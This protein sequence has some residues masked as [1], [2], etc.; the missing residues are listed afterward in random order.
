M[1]TIGSQHFA[2]AA[3]QGPD[4]TDPSSDDSCSLGVQEGVKTAL[5]IAAPMF[6]AIPFAGSPLKAAVDGLL[7]IL[8]AADVSFDFS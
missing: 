7:E 8:K 5:T 3:T 4:L 1:L 2:A 6:G